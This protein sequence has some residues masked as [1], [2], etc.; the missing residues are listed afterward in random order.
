[1]SDLASQKI[2]RP[3]ERYQWLLALAIMVLLAEMLVPERKETRRASVA[4]G[5]PKAAGVALLLCL[6]PAAASAGPTKAL[7]QYDSG[8]FEASQLEYE[9]M[10]KGKKSDD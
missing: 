4:A 9:R 6:L 2:K 1:K 10:L 5:V 8:K 3:H 7:R